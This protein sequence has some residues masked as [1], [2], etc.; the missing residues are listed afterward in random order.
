MS[1]LPSFIWVSADM[2]ELTLVNFM[3]VVER[4]KEGL[5]RSKERRVEQRS[6]RKQS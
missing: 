6:C 2:M 5:I 1:D 3:L 4:S